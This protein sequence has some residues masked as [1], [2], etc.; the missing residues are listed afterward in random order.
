MANA[1]ENWA[2]GVIAQYE[3]RVANLLG[4][5]L[6]YDVKVKSLPHDEYIARFGDT[7]QVGNWNYDDKTIYI[8]RQNA[9]RN[10]PGF[11]VHELTHAFQGNSPRS[12]NQTEGLAD[13][14]RYHFGLTTPGWTLRPSGQKWIDMT[15]ATATEIVSALRRG[16]KRFRPPRLPW[17]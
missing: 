17:R 9:S 11:V 16:A 3:N 6:P 12:A 15:P 5:D 1:L 10:D 2:Y 7:G 8:D 14:V 4:F 13:F